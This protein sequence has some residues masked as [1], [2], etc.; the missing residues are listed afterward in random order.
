MSTEIA[1]QEK[2]TI[3]QR[4]LNSIVGQV[5]NDGAKME[6]TPQMKMIAMSYFVK[7]DSVLSELETKRDPQKLPLEYGWKNV[8]MEK[9]ARDVAHFS[10]LGLN[11]SMKNFINPIPY[12]NGKTNKHDITFIPGY[13]GLEYVAKRYAFDEFVDGYVQ[14]VYANDFFKPIFKDANNQV[15]GYEFQVVNPF[16]RGDIVGGF[17]YQIY[18]D[19]TLNRLK[20]YT[21]AEIEKRKP[22]NASAE[23]WGGE[24]TVWASGK[25]TGTEKVEG[26]YTEMLEKTL[27]RACFDKVSKDP[28]KI[29]A[30]FMAF[31]EI[32][33]KAEKIEFSET[34]FTPHVEVKMEL[35]EPKTETIEV[36]PIEKVEAKKVEK[37]ATKVNV[38]LESIDFPM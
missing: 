37:V 25:P 2:K 10:K 12:K 31:N 36:K 6:F 9:L 32:A 11:P 4:F 24:K 33:E 38:E 27:K 1:E 19:P 7:I 8:N 18:K 15:E 13:E 3:G 26:W 14:L 35:E 23:F 20:F 34:D 28:M 21:L 5:A 29:D 16:D 22:K 17:W 30:E